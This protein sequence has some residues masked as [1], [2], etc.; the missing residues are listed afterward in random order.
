MA[1]LHS[2]ALTPQLPRPPPQPRLAPR[3]RRKAKELPSLTTDSN[4]NHHAVH[5]NPQGTPALKDPQ[6]AVTPWVMDHLTEDPQEE[7]D[8]RVEAAEATQRPISSLTTTG[9]R[10]DDATASCSRLFQT[11]IRCRN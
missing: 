4:L 8:P 9:D 2:A 6:E 3:D 10:E 5:H 7:A 1:C 11:R